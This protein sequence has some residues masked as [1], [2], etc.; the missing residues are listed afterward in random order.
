MKN[1]EM[2][3]KEVYEKV[4]IKCFNQLNK[5]YDEDLYKL[6]LSS[7]IINGYAKVVHVVEKATQII[8]AVFPIIVS[9]EN[10]SAP[11]IRNIFIHELLIGTHKG[12][13]KTHA[14]LFQINK[15]SC[16]IIDS[17]C[18][19]ISEPLNEGVIWSIE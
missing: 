15:F 1:V 7:K 4:F 12:I 11:F 8:Y 6:E 19:F 16:E 9:Y 5:F 18:Y 13:T 10:L 2:I 14:I 3:D 17:A